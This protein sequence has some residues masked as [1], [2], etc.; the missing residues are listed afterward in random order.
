MYL[1]LR[2]VCELNN[3]LTLVGHEYWVAFIACNGWFIHWICRIS[4]KRECWKCRLDCLF[5]W[6]FALHVKTLPFSGKKCSFIWKVRT[7]NRKVLGSTPHRSTR[8][9][10]LPSMLVSFTEFSKVGRCSL[11]IR[12]KRFLCLQNKI[13]RTLHNVV[14]LAFEWTSFSA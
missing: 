8:I 13:S 12:R 3:L 9:S 1:L 7:S 6:P 10:F 5:T 4:V 14:T 11:Q 2:V